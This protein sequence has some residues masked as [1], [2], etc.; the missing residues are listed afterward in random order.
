MKEVAG[1]R[2]LSLNEVEAVMGGQ[3]LCYAVCTAIMIQDCSLANGQECI[4][5]WQTVCHDV[6]Y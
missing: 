4:T 6:C 2:E 5:H 3:Q 1:I